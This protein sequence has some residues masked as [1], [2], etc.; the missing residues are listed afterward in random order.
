MRSSLAPPLAVW[1]A[2]AGTVVIAAAVFGYDPFDSSTWAR[3]DSV[4][5][6]AIARDGYDLDHCRVAY[7]PDD[8]CGDAGWFPAYPWLV[9]ALHRLGLPLQGTAVVV[10][11][12]FAAATLVLLARTS[13]AVAVATSPSGLWRTPPGPP[14][15]S[16]TTPSSHFRCSPSSPL[17]T[18]GS[19]FA[20]VTCSPVP[21]ARWRCSLTRWGS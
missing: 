17:P 13:C 9:G 5:Y 10:S 20:A 21:P 12:L 16:T 14:A 11:W 4:H 6:E 8:W 1:A 2:A 3:W 7:P 15:R 18:C 19:S